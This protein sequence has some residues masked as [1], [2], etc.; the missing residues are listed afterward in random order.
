LIKDVI[1]PDES[2]FFLLFYRR[3][4]QYFRIN[5]SSLA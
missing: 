3:R 5:T 2:Q 1:K 4:S